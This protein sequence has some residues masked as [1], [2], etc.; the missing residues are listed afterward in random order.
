M[1]RKEAGKPA[2]VLSFISSSLGYV[3]GILLEQFG[4]SFI[5]LNK[6][7]SKK[8]HFGGTIS[9]SN[10]KIIERR[11]IDTPNKQKNTHTNP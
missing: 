9:K 6:M 1:S 5:Y 8:Y 7:K 2:S 11:Y 10:W 4:L 3:D